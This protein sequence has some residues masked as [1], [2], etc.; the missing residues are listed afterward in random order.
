MDVDLFSYA[1]SATLTEESDKALVGQYVSTLS[2]EALPEDYFEEMDRAVIDSD[3]SDAVVKAMTENGYLVSAL[4]FLAKK[5]DFRLIDFTDSGNASAVVE[6]CEAL[7]KYDETLIPKIRKEIIV[8]FCENNEP[9]KI[10]NDYN[11]LFYGSYPLLTDEEIREFPDAVSMLYGLNRTL[12]TE[13]N[14]R[15]LVD[16]IAQKANPAA[17]L[18]TIGLLFI[19]DQDDDYASDEIGAEIIRS[20]DLE[21]IGFMAL[22]MED[23]E[24][25]V[26]H[27]GK[28]MD[29]DDAKNA[30]DFMKR[31]HTLLPSLEKVV[32]QEEPQWYKSLI[33]DID[34]PTE[35]TL[36]W[37]SQ[38]TVDFPIAARTLALLAEKGEQQKYLQGKVLLESSFVFPYPEVDASVAVAEYTP[39]SPIWDAIKDNGELIEYILASKAYEDFFEQDIPEVLQPLYRAKQTADFVKFVLDHVERSEAVFYLENMGE[40]RDAENSIHILRLLQESE[41]IAFLE[42]DQVLEKV[43]ERLWEN[44]P[45]HIGYKAR[46]TRARNEYFS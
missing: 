42:Q 18:K 14:I 41:Y 21:R 1:L 29:F 17:A 31:I 19:S 20:L 16:W 38:N 10:Y 5:Q 11:D 44:T 27:F 12:I 22:S 7:L 2:P 26:A 9:T 8:R 36:E 4:A 46:F 13:D 15:W 32:A 33:H 40:I 28:H 45:G 34:M 43:K 23:K 6:A 35:Y 39:D 37:I 25:A 30:F 3:L 24:K